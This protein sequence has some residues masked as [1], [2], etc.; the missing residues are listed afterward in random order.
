MQQHTIYLPSNHNYSKIHTIMKSP[1]PTLLVIRRQL[2]PSVHQKLRQHIPEM[3]HA[4]PELQIKWRRFGEVGVSLVE[5]GEYQQ[6]IEKPDSMLRQATAQRVETTINQKIVPIMPSEGTVI[7]PTVRGI[8][9]LGNGRFVSIAY[10][11]EPQPITDERQRFTQLLDKM[12]G[13]NSH[14][15]DFIP[16]VSVATVDKINA[17]QRILDAFQSITPNTL[18][19]YPARA[20]A[21]QSNLSSQRK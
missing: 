2:V 7:Y 17:D 10:I 8:S 21:D 20:I 11:L 14:W 16:H 19:L 5:R 15:G 4:M 12:N 13:V 1:D 9:F 6:A 3:N 18:A